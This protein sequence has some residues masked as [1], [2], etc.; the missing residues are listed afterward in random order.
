MAEPVDLSWMYGLKNYWIGI[1]PPVSMKWQW[2]QSIDALLSN[3]EAGYMAIEWNLGDTGGLTGLD[4]LKVVMSRNAYPWLG[5]CIFESDSAKRQEMVDYCKDNLRKVGF[6]PSAD[7]PTYFDKN[8]RL[9]E[10]SDAGR[11][12]I[13]VAF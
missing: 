1:T 9:F 13:Q 11:S 7:E 4:V 5:I 6:N 8:F 10:S 3:R 2:I 12:W